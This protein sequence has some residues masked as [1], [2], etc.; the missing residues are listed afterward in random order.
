[1]GAGGIGPA[2]PDGGCAGVS[3]EVDQDLGVQ[4]DSRAIVDAARREELKV[5]RDLILEGLTPAGGPQRPLSAARKAEP[6]GVWAKRGVKAGF[7]AD[8][9]RA[10][11]IGGD[12]AAAESQVAVPTN[13]NVFIATEA[14]RG[15]RYLGIGPAHAAAAERVTAEVVEAALAGLRVVA[16]QGQPTAAEEAS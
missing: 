11:A 9:L 4:I 10:T 3:L 1:T 16:E 2:G 13:R 5:S 6:G 15:V 8:N 7:T 12:T 14:Q